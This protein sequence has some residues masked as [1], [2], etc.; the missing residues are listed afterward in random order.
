M[1][2]LDYMSIMS[3]V[4]SV[5]TFGGATGRAPD[6]AQFLT[7]PCSVVLN[8]DGRI[9]RSLLHGKINRQI[10]CDGTQKTGNK[11]VSST[12]GIHDVNRLNAVAVETLPIESQAAV[13][14]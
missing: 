14:P 6:P 10:V 12:H 8:S 7:L 11:G 3:L 2:L 9:G 5:I 1:S 4:P 13:A